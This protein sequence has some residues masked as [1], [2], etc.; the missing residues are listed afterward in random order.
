MKLRN[1]DVD[2]LQ[3]G[4][5]A[6]S[7]RLAQSVLR[8]LTS[9]AYYF[10][11]GLLEE[12]A[13]EQG[14]FAI[15][16]PARRQPFQLPMGLSLFFGVTCERN[17]SETHHLHPHQVEVYFVIKGIL[18]MHTWLGLAHK[19][20]LLKA[21][22]ALVV[23]PGSCHF[24]SEWIEPGLAYV[25]RSPNDITGEPAKILCDDSNHGQQYNVTLLRGAL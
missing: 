3:V 5:D 15:M 21:G 14:G 10:D 2:K 12:A 19:E 1:V 20:F 23:P 25:V 24:L 16:V 4:K 7:E 18:R 6:P 17:S 13:K 9:P 8:E 22:D 11:G